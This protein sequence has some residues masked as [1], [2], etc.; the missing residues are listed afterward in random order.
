MANDELDAEIT[1]GLRATILSGAL[2]PGTRLPEE[3][4]ARIFGVSRTRV[5]P[6]LQWLAFE[7]LVEIVKNKGAFIASPTAKD[8]KDVFAARRVIERVTTEIVARTILTSSLRS[9][10]KN[11]EA[12]EGAVLRGDRQRAIRESGEFHVRLAHMAHNAALVSA[13][14][15]LILRT[16][17]IVAL[18][19]GPRTLHSAL[20]HQKDIVLLLERGDAAA[21]ADA[22]EACLFAI[23]KQ[24]DLVKPLE[25]N[26]DLQ[27]I[28]SS[29]ITGGMVRSSGVRLGS[30]R[31]GR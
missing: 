26:V 12:Q 23:E 14:E 6:V 9:L 22:M 3:T 10:R 18:Y 11:I 16:S 4:L 13:L 2:L 1:G 25:R 5:R 8:A 31:A 17:L 24:L 21:A 20:D 29:T 28:I 30:A 27:M 19:G 15:T 7:N